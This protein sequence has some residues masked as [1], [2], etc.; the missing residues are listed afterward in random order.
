MDLLNRKNYWPS[1]LLVL[2][3]L[4]SA[5]SFSLAHEVNHVPFGDN[6]VLCEVCAAGHGL[7][8]GVTV[9]HDV[10]NGQCA[11]DLRVIEPL[12]GHAQANPSPYISRAPPLNHV[13]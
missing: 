1:R 10:P 4:L 6:G 3:I 12:A 11:H 8:A 7:D 9:A 2:L 13:F 5:Q